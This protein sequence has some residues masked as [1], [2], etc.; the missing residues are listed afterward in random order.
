MKGNSTM[1][2]QFSNQT[3]HLKSCINSPNS[4]AT[5]ATKAAEQSKTRFVTRP[6]PAS[7]VD[8]IVQTSAREPAVIF[9]IYEGLLCHYST[10]FKSRFN[11]NR[12]EGSDTVKRLDDEDEDT[13]KI[14]HD[15]PYTQHLPVCPEDK[16]QAVE[17]AR[18][19]CETVGFADRRGIVDLQNAAVDAW[20][21]FYQKYLLLDLLAIVYV[22][23]N[24]HPSSMLRKLCVD[25]FLYCG[26][27]LIE[28]LNE[29]RYF[30]RSHVGFVWDL[31][32][33]LSRNAKSSGG[34]SCCLDW[35]DYFETS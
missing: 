14:F 31:G 12:S 3:L 23:E 15:W 19:M 11:G 6:A 8:T 22:Y 2:L 25:L 20:R 27:D 7:A 24:T 28:L 32:V 35:T 4:V 5:L 10:Y 26:R 33:G 34:G 13:S 9:E 16:L 30:R 21:S 18:D 1:L 29:A 17:Y